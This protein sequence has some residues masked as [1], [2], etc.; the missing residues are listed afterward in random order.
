MRSRNVERREIN[1]VTLANISRRRFLG[2]LLYLC[3]S[4]FLQAGWK[5]NKQCP[6]DDTQALISNLADFY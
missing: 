2:G 3:L 6:N 4:E 5:L 1:M